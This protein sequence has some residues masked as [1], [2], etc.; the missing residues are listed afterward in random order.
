MIVSE[1]HIRS[2]RESDVR[3]MAVW[4]GVHG[5]SWLPFPSMLN[6][7]LG[8]LRLVCINNAMPRR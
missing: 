5:A 8:H 3:R 2:A 4:L 6:L 1:R 7:L